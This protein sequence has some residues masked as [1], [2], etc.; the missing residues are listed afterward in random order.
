MSP[1]QWGINVSIDHRTDIW[2][3]GI[4]LYTMLAGQHPL[5]KNFEQLVMTALVDK[6]MPRLRDAAPGIPT[7]LCDVIDKCLRKKKDERYADARALMRAL[8]P[9]LPTR[10][11]GTRR[12][13]VEDSPYAGLQSFQESDAGRFFG[14]GREIA[15]F[16]MRIADRPLMAVVGP[17]GSGKSSFVRAGVV[18]ALKDSGEKWECQV[19]RPGRTPVSSLAGLLTPIMPTSTS[20]KDVLADLQKN[21]ERLHAEPGYLGSALRAHARRTGQNVL[22]FVDQFEELYTLVEDP[23]ERR[24]FTSC[25]AGLADDPTSPARVVIS[26]RSDFL[27]RVPEDS[28]FMNELSKGLFFMAEPSRDGLRDA[29]VEPAEMA[30]Y[31]FEKEATIDEMLGYLASTS[32]ALP[33]L[34]FTASKLWESRDRGKKMLTEQAYVAMGGIAGALASHADRVITKLSTRAQ[35]LARALLLRLVTP[36]RTRALVSVEE[37]FELGR[38]R[39]ELQHLLDHLVQARL[40]MVQTIGPTTAASVELVHESLIHT[41]PTLKRWLEESQEDVAFLEQL[42]TAARQWAAKKNDPGLLWRGEMADEAK[43]FLRRYTGVLPDVQKNFLVSVISEGERSQKVRRKVVAG[44]VVFLMMLLAAAA[45]ALVVIFGEQRKAVANADAA[46]KAEKAAK[47]SEST[48]VQAK[49]EAEQH[50][51]EVQQ[52]EQERQTAEAGKQVAEQKVVVA[53]SELAQKAEELEAKNGELTGALDD[54]KAATHRAEAA[55]MLAESNEQEA[56]KAREE[57]VK[58]KEEAE[59]LLKKEQERV[60]RLT[61]QLGSPAM[62]TL[63]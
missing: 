10:Y 48:A 53:D 46:K 39:E 43:R 8:E 12:L 32:G 37:V 45:V 27:D 16:M 5:G 60:R 4:M 55:Q 26:L 3:V 50:L 25:L 58:A 38:D 44:V 54:A 21:I 56:K 31:R 28:H 23:A 9:F 33:L 29:L 52:K 17:S 59:A 62:D 6:P 41:W 1:E 11:A 24:A 42:R 57:A 40:L 35:E 15:A 19:V 2:T 61:D 13:E 47:D 14:R 18:P 20:V 7:D 49:A 22:V 63:K 51:K 30:G 36:E 34:Q